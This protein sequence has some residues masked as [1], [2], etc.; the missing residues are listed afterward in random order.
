MGAMHDSTA[1]TTLLWSRMIVLLARWLDIVVFTDHVVGFGDI[2]K[3]CH[4]TAKSLP[5]GVMELRR[6]K[7]RILFVLPSGG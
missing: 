4:R 6:G 3:D 7:K 5:R 2:M 1:G